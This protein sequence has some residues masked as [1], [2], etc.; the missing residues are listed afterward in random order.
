MVS[1]CTRRY[2]VNGDI[3]AL[4][5]DDVMESIEDNDSEVKG[6]GESLS[7]L[8]DDLADEDKNIL[9]SELTEREIKHLSVIATVGRNDDITQEFI[10][11]FTRMKV[12][13]KRRGRKELV[14]IGEAYS[15]WDNREGE[16]RLS[17]LR[18]RLN[19]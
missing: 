16:S 1:I 9:F 4:D 14:Q 17:R 10:D 8:L 6:I 7:G 5:Q 3:M 11:N 2:R 15:G 19:L 12:S 13:K 18:G